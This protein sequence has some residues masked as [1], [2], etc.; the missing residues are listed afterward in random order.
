MERFEDD[1]LFFRR[2]ANS[3]VSHLEGNDGRRAVQ[4]GMFRTP[5]RSRGRNT[6]RYAA[7]LRKLECIRQQVLQYLQQSLRIGDDGSTES[8]IEYD[9]KRQPSVLRFVPERAFERIAHAAI[10]QFFGL[11]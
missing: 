11:N 8:W 3:R 7:F 2:Y 6:Q 5:T 10:W 1:L 9:A 4:H